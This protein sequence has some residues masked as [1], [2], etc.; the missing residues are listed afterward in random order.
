MRHTRSKWMKLPRFYIRTKRTPPD[1]H[2]VRPDRRIVGAVDRETRLLYPRT[3]LDY[4]PRNEFLM[5]APL[6]AS[7]GQSITAFPRA[8]CA[9]IGTLPTHRRW[10]AWPSLQTLL[11]KHYGIRA[12][13]NLTP[14]T[15]R[16]Y[17]MAS[18]I[19]ALST[20]RL[21]MMIDFTYLAR[22][23]ILSLLDDDTHDC[24]W[25]NKVCHPLP[26]SQ[27]ASSGLIIQDSRSSR[28]NSQRK[29]LALITLSRY[30]LYR[31]NNRVATAALPPSDRID[32][33]VCTARLFYM[34]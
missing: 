21:V 31:S 13:W 10:Q 18:I 11:P 25:H 1:L 6:R 19:C 34:L 29:V 20:L 3:Q 28:S 9:D 2:R 5:R 32:R 24:T 8:T 33:H 22:S 27:F 15:A 14:H 23:A 30:R 12:R 17:Y 7:D 26:E 16:R 4:S